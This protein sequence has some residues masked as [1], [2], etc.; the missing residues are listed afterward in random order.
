MEE[1]SCYGPNKG[2][3]VVEKLGKQKILKIFIQPGSQQLGTKLGSVLSKLGSV[4][5]ELCVITGTQ[6]IN[7]ILS[8][9]I[10]GVDDGKVSISR[11]KV[12]KMKEFIQVESP[13]PFLINNQ[14]ARDVT[15]HF[16]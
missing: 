5:F 1:F 4:N 15:S 2:S 16:L 11:A 14:T 10:P 9:M 13:H 7:A 12:E 8:Q 6:S 3:E